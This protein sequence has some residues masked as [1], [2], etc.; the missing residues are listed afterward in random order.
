MTENE[1][2]LAE[3]VSRLEGLVSQLAEQLAKA[4]AGVATLPF[5]LRGA[6]G[7][8]LFEVEQDM[9]GVSVCLY[10][11]QGKRAL[12]LGCLPDGGFIDVLH[13]STGKLIVTLAAT[14]N[15][16]TIEISDAQGGTLLYVAP[17]HS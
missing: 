13:A 16:G 9:D 1:L 11:A 5:V 6:N 12:V 17:D 4:Q 7:Q 15:G 8:A 10:D 3:R 14:P 2:L